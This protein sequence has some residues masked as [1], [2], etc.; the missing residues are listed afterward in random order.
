MRSFSDNID[1]MVSACRLLKNLGC[2]EKL[3]K[4]MVDANVC[5]ALSKAMEGHKDNETIQKQAREALKQ[6]L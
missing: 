4:P 2:Y 6:L 5:S 1:V 3:L